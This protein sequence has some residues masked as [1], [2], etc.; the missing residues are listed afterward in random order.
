MN[1]MNS[2]MECNRAFSAKAFQGYQVLFYV[3]MFMLD[4]CFEDFGAWNLHVFHNLR[5]SRG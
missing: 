4:A 2:S 5:D 3:D 1:H